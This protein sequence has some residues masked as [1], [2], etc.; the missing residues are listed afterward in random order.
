VARFSRGSAT[1]IPKAENF[2]FDRQGLP[3]R[4]RSAP[5]DMMFERLRHG[6]DLAGTEEIAYYFAELVERLGNE[7]AGRETQ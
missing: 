6:S 1:A 2:G 5:Y 7:L 4:R 3:Y